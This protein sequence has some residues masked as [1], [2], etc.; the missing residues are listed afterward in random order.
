MRSGVRSYTSLVQAHTHSFF[1]IV[2]PF[3]GALDIEIAGRGGRIDRDW[4]A[5]IGAGDRHAF[6]ANQEANRFLVLDVREPEGASRT[7]DLLGRLAE[8]RSLPA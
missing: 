2:L 7:S 1:Q 3:R 5:V 8:Q 4:A 6:S